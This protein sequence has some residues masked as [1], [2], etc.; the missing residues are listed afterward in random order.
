[1]HDILDVHVEE[2]DKNA[3]E[4]LNACMESISAMAV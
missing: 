4:R 3:F 2:T 1:M